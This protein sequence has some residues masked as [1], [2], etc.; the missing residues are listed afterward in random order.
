MRVFPFFQRHRDA[1]CCF[2]SA[3]LTKHRVSGSAPSYGAYRGHCE[4]CQMST[5]YDCT[6]FNVVRKED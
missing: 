1:V 4:A 6:E 5:W 2:C 3:P